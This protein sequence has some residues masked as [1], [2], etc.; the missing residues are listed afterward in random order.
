MEKFADRQNHSTPLLKP[1]VNRNSL[2]RALVA[3]AVL[4]AVLLGLVMLLLIGVETG[5]VALLTGL[6]FATLPVPVYVLLLLWIDRYEAEPTWMLATA[7]FWGA[8]VAVF[9][10]Y[11]LNTAGSLIVYL[12]TNNENAGKIFG[13]VV[14]APVVEEI[15]KGLVVLLL[16]FKKDEFDDVVDGIVYAGMVGL[17]FAM[18]E[19]IQYYGN[20]ALAGSREDLTGTLILRG[21]LSPFLHPLCTSM[22]GIALGLARQSS[23]RFVKLLVPVFGLALAITLHAT[24]NA[25]AMLL[26]GAGFLLIYFLVMLPVF[27]ATLVTV[28]FAL[29]REGRIV[30]EQLLCDLQ[31]GV[32]TAEEYQCL[33]SVRGR[34][35]A[36][37][38]ALRSGGF[39]DW[40]AR[41]RFNQTASELA[42]HRH[43]VAA[44]IYTS[45][46][47]AH[48][49][50][51]AYLQLLRD[52]QERLRE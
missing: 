35:G 49:R 23:K 39:R 13:T 22:T 2:K 24:W 47:V 5:A 18:T 42:F 48:E 40:H 38:R 45:D 12:I 15:S 36:S 8:L 19:N 11:V 16:F 3:A 51:A 6:V 37:L 29:R 31:S 4:C 7:F 43:R 10:A 44:G 28:F 34:L 30:R 50:E 17:G 1:S 9:I 26:G 33:C 52:L 27:V 20:A 21:A 41:A 46:H 14:S 32:F 25:A